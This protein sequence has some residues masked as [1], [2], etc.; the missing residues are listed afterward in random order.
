MVGVN[1]DLL[2]SVWPEHDVNGME[3]AV[4]VILVLAGMELIFFIEACIV[5]SFGSVTKTVLI[6]HQCLSYC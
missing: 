2:D 6:T 4:E 1:E 3:S 5:L